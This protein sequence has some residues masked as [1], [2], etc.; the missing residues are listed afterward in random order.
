MFNIYFKN[1]RL[2]CFPALE[3]T[4]KTTFQFYKVV[5]REHHSGEGKTS[6][7]TLLR[8]YSDAKFYHNRPRFVEDTTQRF[9]LLFVGHGVYSAFTELDWFLT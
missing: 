5:Y 6:I 1:C 8:I 9:C 7:I 3:I 2:C 4:T